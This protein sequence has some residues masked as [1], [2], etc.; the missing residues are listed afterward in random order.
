MQRILVIILSTT[1]LLFCSTLNAQENTIGDK[2]DYILILNSYGYVNAWST[3]LSKLIRYE[4]EKHEPNVIVSIGYAGITNRSSFI[5]GRFGMQAAF[6]N[7]RVSKEVPTP[8]VLILVGDE[9]WMYYRIMNLRG[10]WD[11]VPVLLV[12]VHSEIMDDFSNFHTSR[13][14]QDS[15]LIPLENS[16]KNL[17]VTALV[18]KDNEAYTLWL[19]KQLMPD[20]K[21][22]AF[23]STG[24]YQDEYALALIKSVIS[25]QYPELELYVIHADGKNADALIQK[26]LLALSENSAILIGSASVPE[27]VN[28]PV[29]QLNDRKL[30]GEMTVGGYYPLKKN[31]AQDAADIA[32]RIHRGESPDSISFTLVSGE[33]PHLNKTALEY[34]NLDKAASNVPDVE[35]INIPVPFFQRY[36]RPLILLSLMVII[37]ITIFLLNRRG[38]RHRSYLLQSM[39]KY[40]KIY[41]EYQIVYKNMPM[42]LAFFDRKGYLLNRNKSSDLFFDKVPADELTDFN[43]LESELLDKTSKMKISK[44]LLVNK[45]FEYGDRSLRLIFRYI[46][47]EETE[48]EDILMIVLDYTNIQK[49]KAAKERIYDIFNFAMNASSLGVA[50]YNLIDSSRFATEAWYKNLCIDASVDALNVYQA[51][52][53]ED[54]TK[55][56]YFLNHI[57]E[58]GEVYFNETVRVQEG[59]TIHWLHYVIQLLEYG[60]EE[61]RIIV[62]ELALNIDNQKYSEQELDRALQSAKESD[63]LKNAFVA[64]MSSDI[65]PALDELVVLSNRLIETTDDSEKESLMTRIEQNNDVLLKYVER[66]IELSRTDVTKN[67]RL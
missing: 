60:P 4:I 51:V 8:T 46:Q 23:L 37:L 14:I 10:I 12:G 67:Q 39:E 15:L 49:E 5:S 1:F 29:F 28:V 63:R 2:S 36:M 30:E 57:G 42:G 31:Y 25:I 58:D 55:I 21:Q 32:L 54:R 52:V 40:K 61:G 27:N 65:R 43:L 20:L 3:E 53:E 24:G 38:K 45:V 18:N 22:I 26:D 16:R 33:V 13:T 41:D 19:M 59:E 50:E 48:S 66:I 64:N 34:F 47:D 7:G 44:K 9:S 17:P 62:A 11:K 6:A 56:E 35:Y